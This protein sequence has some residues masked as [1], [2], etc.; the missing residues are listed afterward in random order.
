[1]KRIAFILSCTMIVGCGA[2]RAPARDATTGMI[3]ALEHPGAENR[4]T[5]KIHTLLEKTVDEAL[6]PNSPPK[7][8]ALARDI[9]SGALQAM[10]SQSPEQR[11][12]VQAMVHDAVVAALAAAK[13]EMRGM[14]QSAGQTGE[15]LTNGL[16]QGVVRNDAAIASLIGQSTHAAGQE[17]V[18][19]ASDQLAVSFGDNM[20]PDSVIG[21]AINATAERASAGLMQGIALQLSN[22][23]L[24]CASKDP[25]LCQ[26][27]ILRRASRSISMGMTEGV[28]Q[29]LS[30]WH[31]V[32]AS[33][34][35]IVLAMMAGWLIRRLV[36][37][38]YFV[39]RAASGR[40][41]GGSGGHLLG[42][43]AHAH[44]RAKRPAPTTRRLSK[45]TRTR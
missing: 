6:D 8:A 36:E 42:G 9:T 22:E 20:G 38:G 1:M 39:D 40:R 31:L 15:S 32:A 33:A 17:L 35:G 28:G 44:A 19:G 2:I 13:E 26:G 21:R 10:A 4:L 12:L 7:A 23:D 5:G 43:R 14:P 3:D 27:D 24:A 16:V 25:K 37:R 41:S 30:Y 34:V 18:R 45:T 11:A 29:K